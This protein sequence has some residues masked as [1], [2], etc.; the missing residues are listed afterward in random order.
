MMFIIGVVTGVALA[1]V[2]FIIAVKRTIKSSL[3]E[4]VINLAKKEI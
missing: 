4:I 2:A 1:V 3:D